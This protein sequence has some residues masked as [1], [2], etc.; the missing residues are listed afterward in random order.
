MGRS[1][2]R[3]SST[4]LDK[5]VD[6]DRVPLGRPIGPRA[7]FLLRKMK[8]ELTLARYEDSID[9]VMIKIPTGPL[10]NYWGDDCK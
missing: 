3:P 10:G 7:F 6:I 8:S 4:E 1:I 2:A 5:M 9:T